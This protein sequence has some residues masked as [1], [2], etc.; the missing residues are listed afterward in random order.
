MNSFVT[1]LLKIETS[2]FALSNCEDLGIFCKDLV[3]VE[4][5]FAIHH[6]ILC[7]K[8]RMVKFALLS[9]ATSTE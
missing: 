3:C 1:V 2:Y 4:L 6:Y 9:R 5:T 8:A 7:L